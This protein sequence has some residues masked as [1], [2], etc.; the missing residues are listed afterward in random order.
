MTQAK[1]DT[2]EQMVAET[3]RENRA[4]GRLVD[5]ERAK[6]AALEAALAALRADLETRVNTIMPGEGHKCASCRYIGHHIPCIFC[7]VPVGDHWEQ[8]ERGG[9]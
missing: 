7:T 1:I 4:L 9:A 8:A 5:E 3:E 6:C 2:L